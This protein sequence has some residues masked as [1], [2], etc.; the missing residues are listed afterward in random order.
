MMNWFCEFIVAT[1][2]LL[3]AQLAVKEMLEGEKSSG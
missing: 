3:Q 2:S 1:R